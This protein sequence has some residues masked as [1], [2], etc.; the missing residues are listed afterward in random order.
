MQA[1][2]D[3][4]GNLRLSGTAQNWQTVFRLKSFG[5]GAQQ[6]AVGGSTWQAKEN[7][8][9]N[10]RAEF[11]LTEY[12]ENRPDG[13]EQGFILDAK[14]SGDENLSLILQTSGA[15]KPS[16]SA[17]EQKIILSDASGAEVLRYEKLK[18]WDAEKQRLSGIPTTSDAR[19][20][21][22]IAVSLETLIVG[23]PANSNYRGAAFTYN[24]RNPAFDFDGD[25]KSDIA[26]FR[27]SN[28]TCYIN[29][30]TAGTLIQQ[31]GQTG[32]RPVPNAFVP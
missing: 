31:F 29:R 32:D 25:G 4:S 26:F 21:A 20:G 22:S 5:R 13:L 9:E 6:S 14:P 11:G 10:R 24:L 27:P 17:D 28:A 7:R 1:K 15:L 16:A 19:F 2:F 30:S 8:V 23:A 18:V 12:F 3:D